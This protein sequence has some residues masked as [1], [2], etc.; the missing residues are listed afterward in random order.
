MVNF[1]SQA[2]AVVLDHLD[3][4]DGGG[5][6]WKVWEEMMVMVVSSR[7]REGDGVKGWWIGDGCQD[8]WEKSEFE[9]EWEKIQRWRCD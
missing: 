2:L 5:C 6:D 4:G 3:G 9:N 7:Q 8:T 1:D